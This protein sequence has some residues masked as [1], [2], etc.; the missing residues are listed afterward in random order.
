MI[1]ATMESEHYSWIAFGE[2]EAAAL[3]NMKK[4]FEQWA[5]DS[6][7]EDISDY[8]GLGFFEIDPGVVYRD[9]SEIRVRPK[10]AV[11]IHTP[12]RRKKA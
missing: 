3:A 9:T 6:P 5:P 11:D 10:E 1:L 4:A 2:T 8:Y 7:V 12:C